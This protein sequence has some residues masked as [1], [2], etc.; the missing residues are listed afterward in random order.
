MKRNFIFMGLVKRGLGLQSQFFNLDHHLNI[1]RLRG[2]C[3]NRDF[4]VSKI[5]GAHCTRINALY[6]FKQLL[7]L[8]RADAIVGSVGDSFDLK[9]WPYCKVIDATTTTIEQ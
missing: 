9:T 7:E 4:G 3:L 6:A 1:Q 8:D 2:N 5:I